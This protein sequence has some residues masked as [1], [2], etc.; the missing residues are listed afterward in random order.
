MRTK[1]EITTDLDK[2][3]RQLQSAINQNQKPLISMYESKIEKFSAE[4]LEVEA[5]NVAITDMKESKKN[6]YASLSPKKVSKKHTPKAKKGNKASKE[7]KPKGV[8]SEWN[9]FV[10]KNQINYITKYGSFSEA[11]KKM[12]VDYK[13]DK[14][15]TKTK[16]PTK[17]GT[18][19]ELVDTGKDVWILKNIKTDKADFEIEKNKEGKYKV[20][21]LTKEDKVFDTLEEALEHIRKTFLKGELGKIMQDKKHKAKIAA[22]YKKKHPNPLTAVQ[23][24][25]KAEEKAVEKLEEKAE[26]NESID[27]QVKVLLKIVERILAKIS[28]LTGENY[29]LSKN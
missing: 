14:A 3:K 5:K 16:E 11:I 26:K 18:Y 7:V 15:K 4:L 2:A 28:K 8:S 29:K 12:S 1:V 9:H 25:K 27:G 19:H 24:L 22:E 10:K 13:S 20:T 17:I 21:C 6:K 23:I